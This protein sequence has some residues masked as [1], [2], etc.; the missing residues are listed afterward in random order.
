MI[1]GVDDDTIA[2]QIR[3]R[4]IVATDV[5]METDAISGAGSVT[6]KAK[7]SFDRSTAPSTTIFLF[8]SLGLKSALAALAAFLL[9]GGLRGTMSICT[10][11]DRLFFRSAP[12]TTGRLH[13]VA[14]AA[15]AMLVAS[16]A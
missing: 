13:Y 8:E 4:R 11:S 5:G 9:R 3:T 1:V 16:S 14:T 15:S 10:V 6:G 12:L 7:S 2:Q